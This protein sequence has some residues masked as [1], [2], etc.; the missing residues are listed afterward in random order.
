MEII[1][2]QDIRKFKT[3]DIGNFSF[4]EVGFI[5]AAAVLGYGVY[6]IEKKVLMME[7]L[8]VAPIV[9][10]AMIPLIIGFFKPQG[11][12]FW[13]FLNTVVKENMVEPKI[14]IWESDFVPDM[15]KY[16]EIYGEEYALTD[17]RLVQLRELE[18]IE[19]G[20][21][22]PKATKEELNKIVR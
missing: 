10:V 12:T 22:P 4:K 17:E 9:L 3:K 1:L 11:M 8:N 7:N 19:H 18:R 2:N 6:Y 13:Q 20:E 16:G 15:D 14:Y 5:A 21:K